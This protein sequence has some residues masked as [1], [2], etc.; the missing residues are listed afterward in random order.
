MPVTGERTTLGALAPGTP[1]N[2]EGPMRAGQPIGGHFVLGHVDGVG[3][4]T[5]VQ[6]LGG[7]HRVRVRVPRDLVRYL[8]PRGSVAVD[9]VSLTV[10]DLGGDVF[11]VA[12]IPT[13]LRDTVAGTY[14]PGR[15]VNGEVDMVARYLERL[16][17]R[18]G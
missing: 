7:D 17:G 6:A 15:K 16:T 2:L 18:D 5:E 9:G 8:A 11:T 4:V 12:L 3:E 13:T 14:T 1:V 10:A